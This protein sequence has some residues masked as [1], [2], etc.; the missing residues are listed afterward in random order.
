MVTNTEV[1]FP[2]GTPLKD[3]FIAQLRENTGLQ[4]EYCEQN[5]S[6]V[7]PVDGSRFGLYF[8]NDIVVIVKGMPT[9]NYLLGTTLRTLIDMGG[10]FEGG[11]FGKELP[12]W[13]GMTY[14]EVRNHPKHKYL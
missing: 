6:L 14:S 9:I 13:A 2:N 12:E 3:I 11:F 10:I 8:D 7:N 1:K 4:I 5:I